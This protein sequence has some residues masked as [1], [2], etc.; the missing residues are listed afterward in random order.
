MCGHVTVGT[1]DMNPA[2]DFYRPDP[3]PRHHSNDF[4]AYVRDPDDTK[5]QAVC[6]RVE[7]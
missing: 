1:N 3:R 6:H 4:G 7:G 5:L 2:R